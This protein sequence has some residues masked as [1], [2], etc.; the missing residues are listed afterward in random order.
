MT[1]LVARYADTNWISSMF[2]GL[3]NGMSLFSAAQECAAA[4][5]ERRSP[6]TGALQT[7]GID[8]TAFRRA[9]KRR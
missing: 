7:L 6:S 2:G 1:T 5:R 4:T 3:K 9:I 8:E